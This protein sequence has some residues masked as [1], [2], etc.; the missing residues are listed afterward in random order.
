M[1]TSSNILLTV[2]FGGMAAWLYAGWFRTRDKITI[3]DKRWSASRILF[4]AAG[5]LALATAY[6]YTSRL[7]LI[8]ITAMMLCILAYLITRDGIGEDGVSCNGSFYPWN[9]VRS[10]D[11][12]QEKKG[13]YA[14]FSIWDKQSK[15]NGNYQANISFDLKDE[16]AV[17]ELL[18]KK[19]GKRY[20]RRK[21]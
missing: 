2:L 10:Y 17:K 6:L 19:I 12:Q 18:K 4:I 20:V 9:V 15:K 3:Y 21:K 13:F 11:F 5:V 16:E 8:R 7:D 1:N 14:V